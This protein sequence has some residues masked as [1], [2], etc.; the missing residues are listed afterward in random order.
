MRNQNHFERMSLFLKAVGEPSR[1]SIL[2]CLRKRKHFVGE[3]VDELGTN[4]AN[5]SRHL[6]TLYTNGIVSRKK[7][8]NKVHYA[9]AIPEALSIVD[10]VEDIIR[11]HQ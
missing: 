10:C 6:N 11:R 5:V 3:L 7:K 8:G 2:N 1:I 4:Q 9:I